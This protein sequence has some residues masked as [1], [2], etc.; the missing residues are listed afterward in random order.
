MGGEVKR[1]DWM[2]GKGWDGMGWDGTGGEG[3]EGKGEEGK[4]G[5]GKEVPQVTRPC[6]N[7]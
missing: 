3:G 7:P 1:W 2:G 5:E 6:K 4:E